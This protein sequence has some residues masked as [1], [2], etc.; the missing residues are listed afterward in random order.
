MRVWGREREREVE[1]T[2]GEEGRSSWGQQLKQLLWMT[3]KPQLSKER[4]WSWRRVQGLLTMTVRGLGSKHQ[5][6]YKYLNCV[7][8]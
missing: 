7:E 2:W 1:T 6:L 4:D 8:V 3:N 5:P